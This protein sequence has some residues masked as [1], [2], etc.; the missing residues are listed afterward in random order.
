MSTK[1][2]KTTRRCFLGKA[3]ALIS[4]PYFIP[5]KVL[6]ADGGVSPSNRIYMGGIGIGGRGGSDLG[7]LMAEREV[8]FIANC[9][10]RKAQREKIKGEIDAKNR[11]QDCKSYIDFRELL[12]RSDIDA[13][14]IATSDRWHA[15][16]ATLAMKA[17]KD[18][19]SEKPCSFSI[20]QSQALRAAAR[21]RRVVRQRAEI[22][23]V[24]KGKAVKVELRVT[25]QPFAYGRGSFILLILEG[26]NS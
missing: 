18:V 3:A 5:A 12:A 13:V 11:N 25:C 23:L 20:A 4:A 22:G 26:L 7:A 19:Y 17:G 2:A 16:L 15:P 8:H 6:G 14:L 21:G 9:D 24:R 1:N 10:V